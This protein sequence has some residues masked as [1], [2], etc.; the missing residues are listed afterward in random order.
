MLSLKQALASRNYC[1][2]TVLAHLHGLRISRSRPKVESVKRLH[3]HI[4]KSKTLKQVYER[5]DG[6]SKE[7][8]AVLKACGSRL[9]IAIFTRTYGD[10]R[11][12]RPWRGDESPNWYGFSS[13]TDQLWR[14][15]MITIEKGTPTQVILLNEV[16][17]LLPSV[18]LP[19]PSALL[20][21]SDTPNGRVVL[22]HDL[23]EWI[24]VASAHPTPL[25]K[26]RWLPI[27]A[28]RRIQAGCMVTEDIAH[29][30]GELQ[31]GW[32]RWL[33]YLAEITGIITQTPMGI[34]VTVAGW[35]WLNA[36][37][38]RRW[39]ALLNAIWDDWRSESPVWHRYRLPDVD[40]SAWE[41]LYRHVV[42]C[43]VGVYHRDDVTSALHPYLAIHPA[44][45]SDDD[46]PVFAI[47]P[48]YWDIMAWLGMIKMS[49]THIH[50]LPHVAQSPSPALFRM[51]DNALLLTRPAHPSPSAWVQLNAYAPCVDDVVR[52]DAD[53][54]RCAISRGETVPQIART[55]T[56][57]IGKKLPIGAYEQLEKW[58]K[59]AY[60]RTLQ[61]VHLLTMTDGESLIALRG[62]W[63]MSK[64]VMSIISPHH[65]VIKPAE[66][67]RF[68][69]RMRKIGQPVMVMDNH[70]PAP[71]SWRDAEYAW[72]AIRAY[73]SMSRLVTPTVRIPN[74]VRHALA[75]HIPAHRLV[76]LEQLA[77]DEVD[78]HAQTIQGYASASS[79]EPEMDSEAIR[80]VVHEQWHKRGAVMVVYFSPARGERTTRTIEP[81][82]IY[83]R[84][85]AEYVEAWCRMD[86]GI[87]TFRMD[88]ILWVGGI[89]DKRTGH[90][91]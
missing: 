83:E 49:D 42:A 75:E 1:D 45:Y 64:M 51:T 47:S 25:K 20:T 68:I 22:L 8:L 61:T 10:I 53:A 82:L 40:F 30:R 74:S 33:H 34:S 44:F 88:R 80:A 29:I 12:Y 23:T 59:L 52:V 76:I 78:R 62:N 90:P 85:G 13:I 66:R 11:P 81:T 17:A 50:I 21:P 38:N 18:S 57:L 69:K 37:D 48:A 6:R 67:D 58:E 32:L 87:R 86:E 65:A 4:S 16:R 71:S 55:L 3:A 26:G 39:D 41:M 91:F 19:T 72:F 35:E 60:Q 79:V 43:D 77:R 56:T 70:P 36:P 31:T 2:L 46:M 89:E 54:I 5:L 14:L 73:Q 24:A 63:C 15:G 27:S 84:N 7:A 28:L 9:P